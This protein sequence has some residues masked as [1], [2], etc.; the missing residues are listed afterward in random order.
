MKGVNGKYFISAYIVVLVI[1]LL[2]VTIRYLITMNGLL[3]GM[4]PVMAGNAYFA[5]IGRL[6][7]NNN[8]R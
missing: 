6:I 2:I 4:K 5:I 3:S 1:I 8:I 7:T